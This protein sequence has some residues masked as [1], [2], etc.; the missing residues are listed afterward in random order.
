[1]LESD[2]GSEELTRDH[3]LDPV[4]EP[5]LELALLEELSEGWSTGGGLRLS[6]E[7]TFDCDPV[8]AL[9]LAAAFWISLDRLFPAGDRWE[10]ASSPE[11][12]LEH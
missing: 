1:M 9:G 6:L 7:E 11:L 2:D 10:L 5:E 3:S 12:S 8:L 4:E